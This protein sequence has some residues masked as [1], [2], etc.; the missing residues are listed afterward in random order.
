[1][2][3]LAADPEGEYLQAFGDRDLDETNNAEVEDFCERVADVTGGEFV[4]VSP[5]LAPQEH[6]LL[7]HYSAGGREDLGADSGRS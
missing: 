5:G 6:I 3:A 1:M 7:A 4:L 2:Y